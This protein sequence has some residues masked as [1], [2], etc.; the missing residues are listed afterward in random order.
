MYKIL[1][2]CLLCVS[3]HAKSN[4]KVIENLEK[5]NHLDTPSSKIID[6]KNIINGG[7]FVFIKKNKKIYKAG[8]IY[9]GW[10][11][12]EYLKNPK[13]LRLEWFL[14]SPFGQSGEPNK[15]LYLDHTEALVNLFKNI[16][17]GMT[18]YIPNGIF[19]S[20]KELSCAGK[21]YVTFK[22]EGYALQQNSSFS[23][24]SRL[25]YRGNKKN[26]TFI[27]AGKHPSFMNISIWG[28]GCSKNWKYN[29]LQNNNGT[30]GLKIEGSL[31]A[32]N[33]Q[34]K[35]HKVGLYFWKDSYYT[36][37]TNLE[38]KFTDLALAYKQ[39][40]YNQKF[41]GA[42]FQET[43][44][45]WDRS[46][47]SFSFIG[48]SFEHYDKQNVIF[49]GSKVTFNNCYFETSQKIDTFLRLEKRASLAIRDSMVYTKNSRFFL[50][51]SHG[52]YSVF[53]SEN[54]TIVNDQNM[55]STYTKISPDDKGQIVKMFGDLLE[56]DHPEK[57]HYINQKP[58]V[59]ST[60]IIFPRGCKIY[61]DNGD[62]LEK[63]KRHFI[64]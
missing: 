13:T 10:T 20:T 16:D 25:Q 9:H 3:I 54:N 34:L 48:C 29:H 35:Y 14:N 37:T 38:I 27:D 18:I 4:Q 23:S 59:N 60:D 50:D 7:K 45:I 58:V 6:V 33:L 63:P 30:I 61:F 32:I 15:E 26:A 36:R 49:P 64:Q 39:V 19:Y 42:I 24:N 28:N 43:S 1:L 41:F 52:Y 46:G 62:L 8:L 17:H 44:K 2:V 31:N 11:R 21:H 53:I 55:L 56:F 57:S 51:N 47:R 12:Q 5:L 40:P 22:G